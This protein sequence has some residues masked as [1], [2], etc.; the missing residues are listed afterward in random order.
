MTDSKVSQAALDA[1]RGED[2]V[3]LCFGCRR[4]GRCRL[5]LTAERLVAFGVTATR[6][7]CPRDQEGGPGVAHGGWTAAALDEIMGHIPILCGHIAVTGTLTVAFLKPVPVERELEAR[8]WLD[9]REDGKWHNAGE[10]RLVST[11]ALLARATGVF[12]ERDPTVHFDLHRQWMA[13]QDRKAK[14]G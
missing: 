12:V 4:T 9:R 1:L 2:G 8:A 5:G 10:L 6:L 11:G 13:E 7:S 14:G 3:I